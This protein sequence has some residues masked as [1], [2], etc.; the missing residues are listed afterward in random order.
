MNAYMDANVNG[1]LYACTFACLMPMT[2][3]LYACKCIAMT[4]HMYMYV[5]MYVDDK[6]ALIAE[7]TRFIYILPKLSSW[8]CNASVTQFEETKFPKKSSSR[9]LTVVGLISKPSSYR[10]PNTKRRK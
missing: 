7:E 3:S 2:V 1:Y 8:L 5:R 4:D 6:T 9:S 10:N